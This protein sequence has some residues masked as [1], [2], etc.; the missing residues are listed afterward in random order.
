MDK[1]DSGQVILITLFAIII[2]FFLG[3]GF[4]TS[5]YKNKHINNK[6]NLPIVG[7]QY[8]YVN[9]DNPFEQDTIK[10]IVTD[11]KKNKNGEIWV[12]TVP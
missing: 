7:E 4:G 2:S 6:K 10:I 12:V 1:Y 11:V 8:Y 3:I 9:K 5:V